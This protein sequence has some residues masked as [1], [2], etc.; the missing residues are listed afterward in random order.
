MD[1][2]T[3]DFDLGCSFCGVRNFFSKTELYQVKDGHETFR[4]KFCLECGKPLT[5]SCPICHAL[6]QIS[7]NFRKNSQISVLNSYW[8]PNPSLLDTL[9]PSAE[10]QLESYLTQA[11]ELNANTFRLNQRDFLA[12]IPGVQEKLNELQKI[13]HQINQHPLLH[14][15][16]KTHDKLSKQIEKAINEAKDIENSIDLEHKVVNEKKDKQIRKNNLPFLVFQ[17]EFTDFL[18]QARLIRDQEIQNEI[19]ALKPGYE[20]L[21]K[22]IKHNPIFHRLIC[23]TCNTEIFQIQK[24]IYTLSQGNSQLQLVGGSSESTRKNPLKQSP[25]ITVQLE[26]IAHIDKGIK[27]E[28]HGNHAFVLSNGEKEVIGRTFIRNADYLENEAED[29]LFDEDDPFARISNSQ[30]TITK[31]SDDVVLH[32]KEYD[33]RRIGTFLEE[34][35][36]D[37]RLNHKDGLSIE[38]GIKIILPLS[39]E[40][41]NPNQIE[42]KIYLKE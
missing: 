28:F 41:E 23:P 37:I 42:I 35:T 21:D 14:N 39:F 18:K 17:E 6:F 11:K 4:E 24:N 19:D 3:P 29:I 33:E 7:E 13:L 36:N 5:L 25:T 2:N 1:Q 12:L 16:K 22:N 10:K 8:E 15:L 9:I 20:K 27:Y 38:S 31:S 40:H 26:I 32:A 34:R 30:F